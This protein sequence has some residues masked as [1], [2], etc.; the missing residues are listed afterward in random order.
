MTE[1]N[2]GAPF[3]EFGR[4]LTERFARGGIVSGPASQYTGPGS[5]ISP[6]E[7]P[8]VFQQVLHDIIERAEFG[9]K[10]YGHPLGAEA[11]LDFLTN[12]YQEMLDL[13]VYLRGE[14]Y[15]REHERRLL[16]TQSD[17]LETA[18]GIIA[19]AGWDEFSGNINQPK[20][21]GWLDAVLRWRGQYFATLPSGAAAPEEPLAP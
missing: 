10:K 6:S 4:R 17:L 3:A 1:S 15:R 11:Q 9:T 18:W 16:E 12:T 14:I 13:L 20:T 2:P 8:E 5:A 7:G 21:T 19:N